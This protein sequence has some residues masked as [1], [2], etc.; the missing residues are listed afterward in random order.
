MCAAK[1][2]VSSKVCLVIPGGAQIFNSG[3]VVGLDFGPAMGQFSALSSELKG[4]Q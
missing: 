3:G 1:R 2:L 4:V